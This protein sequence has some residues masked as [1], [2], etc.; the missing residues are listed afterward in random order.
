MRGASGLLT[1]SCMY[2]LATP[3]SAIEAIEGPGVMDPG[4]VGSYPR[5]VKPPA[6]ERKFFNKGTS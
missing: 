1:L 2:T 3:G 5:L 6:A 4:V